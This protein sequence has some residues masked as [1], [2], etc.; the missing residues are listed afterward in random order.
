MNRDEALKR[1]DAHLPRGVLASVVH[2]E[3]AG[4][5]VTLVTLGFCRSWTG[6]DAADVVRQSLAA[7]DAWRRDR[8]ARRGGTAKPP[9][10]SAPTSADAARNRRAKDA[11]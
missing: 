1:L 7:V 5:E 4:W 2:E 8:S 3:P 10:L 9:R 6:A 11:G